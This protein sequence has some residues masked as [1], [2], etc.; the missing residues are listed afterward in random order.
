MRGLLSPGEE[1]AGEQFLTALGPL[2]SPA[3]GSRL[4]RARRALRLTR[5]ARAAMEALHP[6]KR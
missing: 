3:S 4:D 2:L 5:A 6:E 1:S